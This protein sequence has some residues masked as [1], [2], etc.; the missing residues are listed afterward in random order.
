MHPEEE[1]NRDELHRKLT[2]AMAS[3]SR[4]GQS[5]VLTQVTS[6]F[7][8][9]RV[10]HKHNKLSVK[11]WPQ[12]KNWDKC[13]KLSLSSNSFC[14]SLTLCHSLYPPLHLSPLPLLSLVQHLYLPRSNILSFWRPLSVSPPPTPCL[15]LSHSV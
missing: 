11:S 7:L 10:E 6:S 3:G 15:T 13:L 12:N 5:S 4:E 2:E 8:D 1:R 14:N 9:Y